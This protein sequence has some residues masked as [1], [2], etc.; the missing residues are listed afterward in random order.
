MDKRIVKLAPSN[1][2]ADFACLGQQVAEAERA[3]A[4]RM[5]IH[6]MHGH[7]MPNLSMGEPIVESRR[8]PMDMPLETH[9]GAGALGLAA[10]QPKSE[11][12][13]MTTKAMKTTK[14]T[15]KYPIPSYPSHYSW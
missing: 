4:D 9:L 5:H 7:F 13:V 14:F 1:L 15:I 6:V 3:R 11:K 10:P 8:R 2:S 12:Q